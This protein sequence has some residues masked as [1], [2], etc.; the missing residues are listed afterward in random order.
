MTIAIL[1]Q[2]AYES[3]GS[4][5][6]I[7]LVLSLFAVSCQCSPPNPQP[8]TLRVINS[9][10][11]PIFID[12]SGGKFGLGVKRNVGGTLYGFDDLACACRFCDNVCSQ[13]CSCPDA[14]MSQVLKLEAGGKAERT[15]GGVVQVAGV[16]QCAPEG[17][18]NQ[19]NAP[20]NEAFDL[21]LCF[22]VQLPE[23]VVF[24][25]G[26]MGFGVLPK[27][28]TTCTSRQFAPQDLEVEISPPKGS[29][30]TTTSD[31]KG[32]GE[33]CFDD[34]CTTGCPANGFPSLGSEWILAIASPDDMGFFEKT[35]R[36]GINRYAGT[37]TLTAAVYQ[38]NTLLL[39][40]SRPGSATGELLTGRLQIKTP[41]GTGVPLTAGTQVTV[42][43]LD[44]GRSVPSRALVIKDSTT[45]EVL[46][47]ADMA[48]GGRLIQN[49][50][51]S[52]F[53]VEDSTSAIG[54]NQTSC[55]RLLFFPLRFSNGASFVELRPGATSQLELAGARWNFLNVSSGAYE[56]TSCPEKD[57]RPWAF[58][59]LTSR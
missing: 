23:G 21:E 55:G 32:A 54:C 50:D 40:F 41:T 49:I 12:A 30:C 22:A 39:S 47:A 46:F 5:M 2:R 8:V 43:L 38:A 57:M 4:D 37:G 45:Q 20:L 3:L 27:V 24:T 7:L 9:T 36:A 44:D 16:N 34:A 25:D 15:W 33:F 42:L 26:G 48:Q 31:C 58:W 6:R 19:Q 52:P 18:L 53:S 51:I 56:N 1:W 28:S 13:S 10:R 11:S 35:T 14:G 29:A 17:C 59:K